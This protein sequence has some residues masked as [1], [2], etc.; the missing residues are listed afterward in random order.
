VSSKNETK[1]EMTTLRSVLKKNHFSLQP[2]QSSPNSQKMFTLVHTHR[3][4]DKNPS[5]PRQ[6]QRGEKSM[7]MGNYEITRD[8]EEN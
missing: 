5:H 3:K 6:F 7:L 4:K 1:V 2:N 8:F